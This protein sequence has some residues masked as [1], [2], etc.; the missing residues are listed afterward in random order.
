MTK[1]LYSYFTSIKL[2]NLNIIVI[3]ILTMIVS[4]NQDN[5]HSSTDDDNLA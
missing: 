4:I 1:F 3:H 5:L 2:V